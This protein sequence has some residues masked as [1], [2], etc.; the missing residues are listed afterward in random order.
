[1]IS[2]PHARTIGFSSDR[3]RRRQDQHR[4]DAAQQVHQ[5]VDVGPVP[6]GE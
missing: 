5:R 1:M 4:R 2:G 3:I 6:N